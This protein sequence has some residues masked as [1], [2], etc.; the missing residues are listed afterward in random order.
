MTWSSPT[1]PSRAQAGPAR[2]RKRFGRLDFRAQLHNLL[3]VVVVLHQ[4]DRW[5]PVM[6]MFPTRTKEQLFLLWGAS[7]ANA[8]LVLGMSAWLY[9]H[10][11]GSGLGVM[12][13]VLCIPL[14]LFLADLATGLVHWGTDTWF[15]GRSWT[16]TIGVAREHHIYP[17]NILHYGPAEH[18]A[19]GS[20]PA[21]MF[22]APIAL[23]IMLFSAGGPAAVAAMIV[24][25]IVCCAML[26]GTYAHRL[27]HVRAR[28]RVVRVL[29]RC[30]LLLDIGHHRHHHCRDHLTH[31]CVFNGWAN[32]VCDRIGFWRFLEIVIHRVTG[33]VPRKDDTHWAS[34][35]RSGRL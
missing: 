35:H 10:F 16:R 30:H 34:E 21:L 18:L 33:A 24:L 28:S 13:A 8:I 7:V 11:S 6:S 14:G 4:F 20:Y 27:G 23:P 3:M 29:Q 25:T 17:Q 32:V 2:D 19:F 1:G 22:L 31:Y 26:F 15:D 5:V 12:W 9:V